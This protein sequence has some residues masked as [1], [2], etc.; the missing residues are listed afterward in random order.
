VLN[1]FYGPLTIDEPVLWELIESKAMQRLKKVHQYGIAYY[2]KD[3]EWYTRFDHSIGVFALLRMHRLPLKEQIAGLLHDVSHTA[4]S[5]FGDMFFNKIDDHTSYQDTIHL[6]YLEKSGLAAILK[7]YG[8][9]PEEVDP[10][11]GSFFAQEQELP[12]LCADRIDYNLQGAY[13]RGVMTREI[14]DAIVKDLRF[15]GRHWTLSHVGNAVQL[16]NFSMNMSF[17][18][19]SAPHQYLGN[20]WLA[21]AMHRAIDTKLLT[22]NDVFFGEDATLWNQLRAAKDPIITEHVAKIVGAEVFA[23]VQ[24]G[25][26]LASTSNDFV[27]VKFRGV[28]PLMRTASGLVRLTKQDALF[29]DRFRHLK[30]KAKL[31][32][33][34]FVHDLKLPSWTFGLEPNALAFKS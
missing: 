8:I 30:A 20:K 21:A 31:G 23:Q 26:A 27:P 17:D 6:W 16:A 33:R 34:L 2:M 11:S 29:G 32:F 12:N 7:K 25:N 9:A 15:N 5:H 22:L 3:K 19:W 24:D 18:S 13:H 28:D 4:F 1:T 10:K 14:V